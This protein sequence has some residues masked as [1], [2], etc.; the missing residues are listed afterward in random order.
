MKLAQLLSIFPQLKWGEAATLD[1]VEV[2]QDSRAVKPGAVFVAIRGNSGDGHRFLS[3][4]AD[5]G[6]IALIVEDDKDIPKTFTGA[7]V[8]VASTRQA[9]DQLA[10][11]FFGNPADELFCVGVTGTNGKTTV[12]YMIEAILNHFGWPTGVMGPID[13]H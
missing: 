3:T 6:A 9:L 13:H 12:T 11:R 7:I 1:A 5:Q 10:K 8:K 2:T 4:A